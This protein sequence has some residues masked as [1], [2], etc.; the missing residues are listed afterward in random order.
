MKIINYELLSNSLIKVNYE[1]DSSY[2]IKFVTNS[3]IEFYQS[4]KS[5]FSISTFLYYIVENRDVIYVKFCYMSINPI[6]IY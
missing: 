5:A 4:K 3:I 2:L 6:R 1:E